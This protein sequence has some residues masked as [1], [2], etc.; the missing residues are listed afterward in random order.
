MGSEIGG[1][2]LMTSS[3]CVTVV[4]WVEPSRFAKKHVMMAHFLEQ[5]INCAFT[6][7]KCLLHAW[8][9]ASHWVMLVTGTRT[10]PLNNSTTW[11]WSLERTQ[12]TENANEAKRRVNGGGQPRASSCSRGPQ[13]VGFSVFTPAQACWRQRPREEDCFPI[14]GAAT[15]WT[16]LAPDCIMSQKNHSVPVTIWSQNFGVSSTAER[17]NI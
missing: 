9:S 17:N 16:D 14:T 12:K 4:T 1:G 13:G 2:L 5:S 8:K 6:K 3:D 11:S 10:Q 15:F 7:C